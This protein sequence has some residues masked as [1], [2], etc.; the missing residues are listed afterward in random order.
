MWVVLALLSALLLGIYE[1]FKKVSVNQNAVIPV[2]FLST[3][4]SALIFLPIAIGSRLYPGIFSELNLYVPV[5]T[6]REHGFVFVKSVIVVSSWILAFYA[7]K[8]LPI[9]IVALSGRPALSGHLLAPF[10]SLA[11]GSTHSSGLVS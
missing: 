11:N 6:L 8:N 3:L 10:W 7:V 2:L 4:T 1:V 9:T 5:M